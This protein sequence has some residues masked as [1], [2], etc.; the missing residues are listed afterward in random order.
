MRKF[1]RAYIE[2]TTRCSLSCS[3]CA[4]G[5]GIRKDLSYEDF[6]R[7]LDQAALFTGTVY[8]HVLGEPL[9]HPDLE[10]MM[11]YAKKKGIASALT[12]NGILLEEKV[13]KWRGQSISRI[14]VSLQAFFDPGNSLGMEQARRC[15]EAAEA[16]RDETKAVVC[17]RLW[18]MDNP[19]DREMADWLMRRYGRKIDE[20]EARSP[21]GFQIGDYTRVQQ[22][23]RFVWPYASRYGRKAGFCQ[24]L[25][26][27]FAVLSDGTVVPC[28]LDAY[29]Q[30]PLG[31][32]LQE[33]LEY[34]LEG[35][36]AQRIYRGFTE[37]TA[38]EE[39]CRRCEFKTRFPVGM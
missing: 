29:G 37:H 38:V 25:R 12:T 24:G 33:P 23:T 31:N 36:R 9:L 1:R 7:I 32:C 16:I 39:L 3:F 27:H 28:C 26:R 6:V 8:Y 35:E 21:N 11:S 30:I 34:I 14:N 10:R 17:F 19:K 18:D 2:I 13:G 15:V 20:R 5:R 4:G 22:Q